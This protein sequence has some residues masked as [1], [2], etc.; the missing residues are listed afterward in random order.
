[1]H[2]RNTMRPDPP[3][4]EHL[5]GSDPSHGSE[6]QLLSNGSAAINAE[7]NWK[8]SRKIEGAMRRANKISYIS[9]KALYDGNHSEYPKGICA[10]YPA[11]FIFVK[12]T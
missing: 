11:L 1:V 3:R 9:D 6:H 7:T 4:Y 2:S 12:G 10:F 8:C 5:K